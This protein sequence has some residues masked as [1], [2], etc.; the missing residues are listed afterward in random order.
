MYTPHQQPQFGVPG[1]P[2]KN[3]WGRNWKWVV[4]TGCL[5][6]LVGVGLFVAA[7]VFIALSAVKATEVY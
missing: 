3:W 7:I 6:L 2:R 1:P 5:G 4:P